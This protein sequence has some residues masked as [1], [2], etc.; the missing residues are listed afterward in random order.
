M[1]MKIS[2]RWSISLLLAIATLGLS[3]SLVSTARAQST[4]DGAI[5]GTVFDATGAVVPGAT[6]VVHNNGTNLDQTLTTDTSGFYKAIKLTPAVYTVTVTS[7]GFETFVAKEVIVTVGSVTNVSP[8]LTIGT[9]TQTVT[10]SGVAP[11]VNTTGAE[12][13]STLN[14]TAISELPIQRARWSAFSQLTPG[15]V[16]DSNGFGLLSFRGVSTLLNNVTVDGADDN[17]AFFS[18]QRGRTRISYSDSEEAVQEFQ[19]NT[20]N[21]SAEYGRSAGGVV[22]TITKSGTNNFHGDASWKNRENNWAARNPFTTLTELNASGGNSTYP[23]KPQDYWDIEAGS[24]GGALKKD[25]LF[26][27]F[28]YDNFYRKFPGNSIASNPGAFFAAPVSASV[29]AGAGGTCTAANNTSAGVLSSNISSTNGIFGGNSNLFTATKAAC[30]IAGIVV[31]GT[32]TAASYGTGVTDYTTGLNSFISNNLGSTP[33]TGKQDIFFPKLDWQ[34]NQKNRASFEVNRMRWTS[35]YGVQTQVSNNYSTGSAMGNDNVSDT[36]GVAKLDTFFSPTVSNEFRYQL[37]MDFEWES[38]PPP[39]AYEVNEMFKTTAGS[40]TFPSWTSYTNPYG[41][42]TYASITGGL[43]LG[44]AYY[45]LRYDYP[46]ELRNQAADTLTWTHENHT[47]KMGGD[48]NRV[49]DLISNIY[50]QNGSFS[51]SGGIGN[52]LED[53]YSPPACSGHPCN[54]FYSSFSQ[55]FGTL[56]FTIPTDDI[57]FFVQD[58]WKVLP[59]LSFSYGL[60]WEYEILPAPEFP[61]PNV[62]ATT[63]Y[64]HP[65][66]NF[67]PRFGFAYDVFGD[68]KTAVR[69]GFGMYYGRIGNDFIFSVE[70]QSGLIQNNV[71]AGQPSLSY[72]TSSASYLPPSYGGPGI[73]PEVLTALPSTGGTPIPGVMYFNPHYK[74]PQ[75]DEADFS[76]ERNLGWNTV[77]SLSYMG[78]FGH[79]LPQTTDDNIVNCGGGVTCPVVGSGTSSFTATPNM[80]YQVA[81]GGPLQSATMTVPFFSVR[82]NSNFTQMLDLFGVSS[83]YNAFVIEA[84]H[85]FSNSIQFDANFTWAHALDYDS[86]TISSTTITATSGFGMLYPNNMQAEY[87]NSNLD[88]PRRFV[89]S[90]VAQ[91]PWKVKGPLGILANGWELAPIFAAQDGLPYS[92]TISGSSPGVLGSGGG[93]NGSDGVF[94]IPLRNNFRE[95]PSQD[96]D[97]RLAKTFRIKEKVNIQIFGEAFNLFNHFNVQTETAEAYTISTSGTITDTAGNT[98]TCGNL[99]AASPHNPCLTPYQPFQSVT[100]ANNTYEYWTRQ[101]QIGAKI[102][103]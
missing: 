78:S 80:T 50:Q 23:T 60:R 47:L 81:N 1:N 29:L 62:P 35:P 22:N 54:A 15:V 70:T 88:V 69:G 4:T 6:V 51:Y 89:L 83:N 98:Q 9:T 19:V 76:I 94:R 102:S 43:A 103:F 16:Q 38:A 28:A 65:K 96:L 45:D 27:F 97:L 36:W 68:G 66:T 48:I 85:R 90:M 17:Q 33:R 24:L 87:G 42:S 86:G 40:T 11:Q 52:F 92:A 59:R 63:H 39:N 79:Y 18:E 64:P 93:V 8:H 55:G 61:N 99:S 25:K 53:I 3:L 84:K 37:G 26:F 41:V 91:S 30:A 71:V 7:K 49:S 57:A 34:I 82:P 75:V 14:Q 77:F 20:S 74:N 5:G 31:E 32:S 58:D 73:F 2:H 101:I 46:R 13:T 10:I 95:S 72:S 12:L 67:G 21:Y 56:S 44:T 100:A